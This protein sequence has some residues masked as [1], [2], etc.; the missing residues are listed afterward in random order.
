MEEKNILSEK[1][2]KV[3][4]ISLIVIVC[5][6]VLVISMALDANSDKRDMGSGEPLY[7]ELD[8]E[9]LD[10]PVYE[11]G[12]NYFELEINIITSVRYGDFVHK[13]RDEDDYYFYIPIFNRLEKEC[14]LT[15][16]QD[17]VCLVNEDTVLVLIYQSSDETLEGVRAFHINQWTGW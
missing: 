9:E 15:E 17:C 11:L 4:F 7:Y 10:L 3:L 13:Y 1:K 14:E 6:L 2:I 8:L 12:Q 16:T 5:A